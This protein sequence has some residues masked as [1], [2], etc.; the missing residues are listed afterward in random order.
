M[1]DVSEA[2]S[3]ISEE[4]QAEYIEDLVRD[5]LHT[6]GPFPGEEYPLEDIGRECGCNILPDFGHPDFIRFS[7]KRFRHMEYPIDTSVIS[8]ADPVGYIANFVHA[9][10]TFT[11]RRWVQIRDKGIVRRLSMN[12][13]FPSDISALELELRDAMEFF[14][15]FREFGQYVPNP[16]TTH[17]AIIETS[18]PDNELHIS[19]IRNPSPFHPAHL[20]PNRYGLPYV[21]SNSQVSIRIRK[22]VFKEP[23]FSLGLYTINELFIQS[24]IKQWLVEGIPYV[25]DQQVPWPIASNDGRLFDKDS[26]DRWDIEME[27]W[28][29]YTI[30]DRGTNETFVIPYYDCTIFNGTDVQPAMK[31][32]RW[33]NAKKEEMRDVLPMSRVMGGFR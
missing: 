5:L 32:N 21:N 15:R 14:F 9:V 31:V 10:R 13:C 33:V 8:N 19:F 17:W 27:D 11:V 30:T 7:D 6:K 2:M 1:S 25:G 16:S 3:D 28:K 24:M 23:G 18:S 29:T 26:I 20:S 12:R 22:S 4:S